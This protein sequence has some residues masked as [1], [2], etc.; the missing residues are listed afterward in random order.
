M[1][2][3]YNAELELV[4]STMDALNSELTRSVYMQPEDRDMIVGAVCIGSAVLLESNPGIG[5]TTIAKTVADAIGGKYRRVQGS[6]DLLPSDITGSEIYNRKGDA[7]DFE[8]RRGPLFANVLLVDEINR[9]SPKSQA[10]LL[11][12]MQEGEVTVGT[13]TYD[14]PEP[15]IVL[16]TQNPQELGQGTY[17]LT[18][19]NQ[20]RFGISLKLEDMEQDALVDVKH[21]NKAQRQNRNSGPKQVIDLAQL[22]DVADF[23]IDKVTDD[24][25][26]VQARA[27]G[28][29]AAMRQ[30]EIVDQSESVLG[31]YRPF[32]QMLMFAKTAAAKENLLTVEPRHVDK[33]AAYVLRH[34]TALTMK[35]TDR[36]ETIDQAIQ[37]AKQRAE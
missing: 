8:F 28:I 9:T 20:D 27:A 33:V 21:K 26:A 15:F 19:A 6:P 22:P 12:A 10:A 4:T 25:L 3:P 32:D 36:G 17:P 35:A 14:L 31:G 23:I 30:L 13:D 16:A 29:L 1:R 24:D 11:Q 7:F 5:K 37:D 18:K 2:S 34:R